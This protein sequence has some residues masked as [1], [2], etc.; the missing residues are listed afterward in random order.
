MKRRGKSGNR[1]PRFCIFPEVVGRVYFTI[2][3]TVRIG[4]NPQRTAMLDISLLRKAAEQEN[5]EAQF[6]LGVALANGD[7]NPS[8]AR[9]ALLLLN[10]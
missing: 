5:P 1:L 6:F 3:F 8:I 7:F 4:I 9:W 2:H 10:A